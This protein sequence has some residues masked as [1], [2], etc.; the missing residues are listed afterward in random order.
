MI[1][2]SQDRNRPVAGSAV[3]GRRKV[4]LSAFGMLIGLICLFILS[5][6][7]RSGDWHDEFEEICSGVQIAE[8]L[9]IEELE[10]LVD[11]AEKLLLQIQALDMPSKKVYIFRLKKCRDFFK[12][13]LETK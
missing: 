11:K 1:S 3:A 4:W 6:I 9:G 12:F 13:I 7:A 10:A 8:S 5:G 2:F